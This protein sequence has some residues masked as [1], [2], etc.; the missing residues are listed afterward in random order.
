MEEIIR[1]GVQRPLNKQSFGKNHC[2]S[3]KVIIN[4]S[5]GLF[6]Y[7]SLT[8]DTVDGSEIWNPANPTCMK[9]VNNGIFTI[10]VIAGFQNHQRRRAQNKQWD[11]SGAKNQLPLRITGNP[12]KKRGLDVYAGVGWISKPPVT[13]DP[14]I[15]RASSFGV[16]F[17]PH[18]KQELI[19]A[20]QE[21][22]WPLRFQMYALRIRGFPTTQKILWPGGA[23]PGWFDHQSILR[24]FGAGKP[25]ILS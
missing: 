14:M 25:G 5:R 11:K 9:P 12:P 15:L 3:R 8:S 6:L 23:L 24:I 1:L 19:F 10:M 18:R 2:S 21:I 16:L 22:R 7:W 4:N 20:R 17:H 13:W